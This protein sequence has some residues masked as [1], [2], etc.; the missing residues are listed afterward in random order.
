MVTAAPDDE[1]IQYATEVTMR[2]EEPV[3]LSGFRVSCFG[4]VTAEALVVVI[5]DDSSVAMPLDVVCD[6][7]DH[8]REYVETEVTE[9]TF[10]AASPAPTTAV[11][12]V[13]GEP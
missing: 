7:S 11:L 6:E 10:A 3:A 9:V 12:F 8:V 5:T 1:I 4:G 13:D 2:F